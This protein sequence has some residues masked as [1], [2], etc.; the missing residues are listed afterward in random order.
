MKLYGLIGYPLGHSFSQRYFSEKFAAENITD[1]EY[2][3]FPLEKIEDVALMIA[4]NKD[5]QGFN[6]TIPYKQAI[7]PYLSEIDPE[8]QAVGA[9]NCVR[10]TRRTDLLSGCPLDSIELKGY[11][12]DV[13]GFRNSLLRFIGDNRPNALVLGTGGSSKAVKY[14]LE[15]LGIEYKNISRKASGK[16]LS[17]EQLNDRII[18]EYPLIINCTP[19][20]TYP[21]VGVC[22]DLPYEAMGPDNYLFD[23]VYNPEVTEFLRRGAAKGAHTRNGYE[24][25]A[26]QAERSWGIWNE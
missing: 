19:L 11:N 4:G 1:C 13:Y 25:L 8:A 17:Y 22:P 20:G 23:L 6:I 12:T 7:I 15:G 16:T 3:N 26:G 18:A 10:I 21:D 24:M 5:L 9:V 14:V 2:R